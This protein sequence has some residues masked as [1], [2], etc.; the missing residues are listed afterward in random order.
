MHVCFH[1]DDTSTALKSYFVKKILLVNCGIG[2][3][4]VSNRV[5]QYGHVVGVCVNFK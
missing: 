5:K 4:E 2:H 3:S 1:A